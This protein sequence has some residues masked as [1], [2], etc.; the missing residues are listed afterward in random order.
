MSSARPATIVYVDADG[1]F[2]SVEQAASSRLRG[3]SVGVIPHVE[4]FPKGVMIFQVGVALF[5]VSKA[6]ERQLYL[7]LNDDEMRRN[8]ERICSA[9]DALNRR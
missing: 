4:D 2:A 7:L 3:R 6:D 9:V 8:W 1:F 5:D